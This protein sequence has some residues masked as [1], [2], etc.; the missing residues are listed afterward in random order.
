MSIIFNTAC[1]SSQYYAPLLL[2]SSFSSPVLPLSRSSAFR[3]LFSRCC[4]LAEITSTYRRLIKC[5]L[6]LFVMI[7][8]PGQADNGTLVLQM[9]GFHVPVLTAKV[10]ALGPVCSCTYINTLFSSRPS[11]E[12]LDTVN[13]ALSNSEGRNSSSFRSHISFCHS[14]SLRHLPAQQHTAGT[15]HTSLPLSLSLRGEA[16]IV[17]ASLPFL[18]LIY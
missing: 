5:V 6:L 18:R 9:V 4:D 13:T 17:C 15:K 11:K 10:L 12:E 14:M 2:M 3:I 1:R 16:L 7:T 8:S